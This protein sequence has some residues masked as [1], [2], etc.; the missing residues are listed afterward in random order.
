MTTSERI[1]QIK[2][3]KNEI[4]REYGYYYYVP[5]AEAYDIQI[6]VTVGCSYDKCLFCDLNGA[7]KFHEIPLDKIN[8]NIKKLRFIHEDKLGSA[9]RFLLA[10]GNPFVLSTE[11]L[12][13]ISEMIHENFPECE[14]ISAFS[15]ADDVTRK[16]IDELKILHDSGYDRLCIGIESGSDEVLKFQ[17]KGV[18]SSENLEAMK[19]LDDSGIKYSAYIMLG[20]GGKNLSEIHVNET[21]K[22]LNSANPFALTVVTLVL[23]RNAK[24]IEK[25]KTH[26]FQRLHPFEALKEGRKLL[27]LL[28]INTIWDATHKTNIFPIK[29][30]IPEHK[31]KLLK[32]ID[33]VISE[34]E[35]QDLK[36]YELKRWKKWGTE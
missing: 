15:R 7:S 31:T 12:L 35:S 17:N 20:L 29:G 26:E 27:S 16:N 3:F 32:R 4:F 30:K 9:K 24:L 25:V 19:I 21:A 36:Q 8:E 34:I 18:A 33:D 2:D 14:Y 6:P 11:K 10:G 22:L 23:F 1:K 5:M 13:R 28:E